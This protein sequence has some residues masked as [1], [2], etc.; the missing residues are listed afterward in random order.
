[1]IFSQIKTKH[2]QPPARASR[3][4]DSDWPT[5]YMRC[6]AVFTFLNFADFNPAI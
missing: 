2:S 1:M 6:H 5:G 4:S 3:V